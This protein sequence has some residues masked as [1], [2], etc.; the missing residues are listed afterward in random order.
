MLQLLLLYPFMCITG[1]WFEAPLVVVMLCTFTFFLPV[2]THLGRF[3]NPISLCYRIIFLFRRSTSAVFTSQRDVSSLVCCQSANVG[4][5]YFWRDATCLL[6]ARC[7]LCITCVYITH[8]ASFVY[9]RPRNASGV[10]L[11]MSCCS[12]VVYCHWIIQKSSVYW[13]KIRAL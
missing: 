3:F 2:G 7:F 9:A 10:G 6:V 13:A 8:L 4:Q 11:E 1:V 12:T 5:M